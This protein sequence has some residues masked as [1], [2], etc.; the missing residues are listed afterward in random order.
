IEASAW[1]DGALLLRLA[2][3]EAAV[4]SARRKLGGDVI[5]SDLAEPFWT[6]LRDQTDEFFI[7]AERAV[8]NGARLWRLSL[9]STA[10]EL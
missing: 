9:P 8:A 1:W 2:G 5:P 7:G 4:G 6:G 3:A 10:P